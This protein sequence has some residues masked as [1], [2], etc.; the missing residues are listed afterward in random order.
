MEAS[1]ENPTERQGE[2]ERG[3]RERERD[4]GMSRKTLLL[5]SLLSFGLW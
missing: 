1:I 5:I 3:M 4:R 2:R